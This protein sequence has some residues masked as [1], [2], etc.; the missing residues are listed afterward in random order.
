MR[1]LWRI[2]GRQKVVI[3]FA[4]RLYMQEIGTDG[5]EVYLGLP[6]RGGASSLPFSL[7]R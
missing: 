5:R 1:P 3:N 4:E 6:I 7:R 2:G